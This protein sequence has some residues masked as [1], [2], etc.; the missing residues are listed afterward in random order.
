MQEELGDL[1]YSVIEPDMDQETAGRVTGMLLEIDLVRLHEVLAD[2]CI[3][4]K[5]VKEALNAC[6][7]TSR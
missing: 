5:R 6:A 4:R 1:I 7:S 3:F 2:D